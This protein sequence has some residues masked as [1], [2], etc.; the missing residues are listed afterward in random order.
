MRRDPESPEARHAPVAGVGYGVGAFLIWGSAPVYFKVIAEVPLFEVMA[1]RILWS[2][3]FVA[4]PLFAL[5]LW[6][7]VWETLRRPR[8]LATLTVSSLFISGSWL[9]FIV[10]SVTDRVLELSLG[11]FS[12]PLLTAALGLLVFKERLRPWQWVA[13]ALAGAGVANLLT[14]VGQVPWVAIWLAITIGGYGMVRKTTVADAF[15]GLFVEVLILCP[16]ALA[17]LVHLDVTGV[18]TFGREGLR[19]DALLA[20]SGVITAL[21]LIFF[22]QAAKRLSLVTFGFMLYITPT[23]Q[24]LLGVFAFHE[25]FTLIHMVT[26]GCIWTGLAVYTVDTTRG[27]RQEAAR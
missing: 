17:Y 22:T 11:L 13:V 1:Q 18:G 7:T 27:A 15:T 16:L 26:F 4:V 5:R 2:A 6:P 8:Q 10:G 12:V 14:Q 20:L 21:P 19:V 9:V 24:F 25:T 3:I 23:C